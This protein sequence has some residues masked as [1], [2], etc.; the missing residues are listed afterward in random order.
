MD[1]F[2]IETSFQFPF[3]KLNELVSYE[4]VKKPSG[5]AYMLL[6][7]LNESNSN[8]ILSNVLENFGVPRSLHYIYAD[9]IS[10]LINQDILSMKNGVQ[11][12]RSEF[13]ALSIGDIE[14]T[15]KGKKIFSEESIP[16]GIT[17]EAK[18]PVFY[19]IAL[20]Q[21]SLSMSGGLEPKPLM[22]SAI[23]EGFMQ[24]FSCEK[25]VEDFI[26]QNKGNRIPIYENGKVVKYELI[27]K[28]VNAFK[29]KNLQ[30]TY[31]NTFIDINI[32]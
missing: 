8:L 14:F 18:I 20:K 23:T 30:D 4:E 19:D 28:E 22:D 21:L 3:F 2:K 17:K 26:N 10:N 5:V 7:L 24:K 15:K 1:K 13:S 32:I 6:V 27:K 29:L 9:T 25:D 16:T 31:I 11:F 12:F